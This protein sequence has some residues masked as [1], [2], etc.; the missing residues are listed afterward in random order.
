[1]RPGTLTP[2]AGSA[3][4]T[5]TVDSASKSDAAG[6]PT[7][8]AR[9]L[10]RAVLSRFNGIQG[11]R[12]VLLDGSFREVRGGAD[13][14]ALSATINVRSRRFY[15]RLV[16]GG[17]LGAAESYL[18]GEWDCDDLTALFRIL[19]GNLESAASIDGRLA[20]ATGALARW[21]HH[22]RRNTR[23]GS[24][25]NIEAHYDL[26][27]DFFRLFLDPTLMYSSAIFE[28]PG[29]TLEEAQVARLERICRTLNLQPS[30]HVVEI[31][32]GWGGFALHAAR[33]Y[34]CRVTTTTISPNQYRCAV[35]RVQSAGLSGRVTVLNQDYR[36]L[37]DR[38]DKLASI[39]MIEAVGY[40]FFDVYF[41]K[42]AS[43]LKPNG[44]MLLQAIVMP[45]RRYKT[46]L[47]SVDFIQKY[48]FPGGC[49]P[50]IA[51]MQE[52]V[53]RTSNL[54]LLALEDFAGHYAQTLRAWRK[55]FLAKLDEVRTLG[56]DERFIRMWHYYLCYCEAAF[57]ERAIGVVHAVWGR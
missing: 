49:L 2:P 16:S 41:G 29:M 10:R 53:A 9:Y 5:R 39:E 43:L 45:E 19:A 51:A 32:S 52:S 57:E 15:Q 21:K 55:R 6:R 40:E 18:D 28:R 4:E 42:C 26:G 20:A 56:Y 30:D 35:E 12:I 24:R 7:I 13:E 47:Q 54:R 37:D 25:R 33:N 31:G 1:M 46:Y 48:I 3:D 14:R 22:I 23:R 36:D 27:D 44:K 34:G 8:L 50:S 11:G 17:S 38:Y